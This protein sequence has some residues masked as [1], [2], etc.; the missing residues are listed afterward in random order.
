[1]LRMLLGSVFCGD[2]PDLNAS[3]PN[4]MADRWSEDSNASDAIG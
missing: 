4:A 2:A 1:M 3:D